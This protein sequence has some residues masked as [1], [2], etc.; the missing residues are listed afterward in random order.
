MSKFIHIRVPNS[1]KGGT[2]VAYDFDKA[3]R[4]VHFVI[5]KCNSNETYCKRIGRAVTG[6]RLA[7]GKRVQELLVPENAGVADTIVRSL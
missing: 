5:G 3:T 7:K 1:Q 2:T 6:G 4:I